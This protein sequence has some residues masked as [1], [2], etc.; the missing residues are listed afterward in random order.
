MLLMTEHEF[1]QLSAFLDGELL[2]DEAAQ[3]EA[4]LADSEEWQ[5]AREQLER[6]DLL[7]RRCMEVAPPLPELPGRVVSPR[8]GT[9]PAMRTPLLVAVV[10][11]VVL[12][13]LVP[14]LWTG[15]TEVPAVPTK[16]GAEQEVTVV[17]RPAPPVEPLGRGEA[18]EPALASQSDAPSAPPDPEPTDALALALAGT[19][20]GQSPAAVIRDVRTGD[21]KVYR[22]GDDVRDGVTLVEVS[23]K[24]V[25]LDKDGESIRLT[26]GALTVEP[27]MERSISGL[28]RVILAIDGQEENFDDLL[29]FAQE[30]ERVGVADEQGEPFATGTLVEREL[31]LQFEEGGAV[32]VLRGR[33]EWTLDSVVMRFQGPTPYGDSVDPDSLE[34]RFTRIPDDEQTVLG[35]L[36]EREREVRAIRD[37]LV[38]Y[39]RDH[40]MLFPVTLD[41]P[42]PEHLDSPEVFATAGDRRV[43]YDGQRRLAT[44]ELASAPRFDTYQAHLTLGERLKAYD[45]MLRKQYGG[46]A[47]LSPAT[48]LTVE[49]SDPGV[50]YTVNAR[51]DMHEK[52]HGTGRRVNATVPEQSE[53]NSWITQD[54]NNLQQLRI[55]IQ[56][57]QNEHEGYSPGGWVS[58]YPEYL[59]DPSVLTSPK[60][61][62]GTDSY[63][64]LYPGAQ[65][66]DLVAGQAGDPAVWTNDRQAA[67]AIASEIPIVLNRTDYPG[68]EPGRNV[69]YLDWHVAFVP[70]DSDEWRTYIEPHL[71]RSR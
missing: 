61:D 39:A 60:D 5:A 7:V 21:Q 62:P 25:L 1:E 24:E 57:F 29:T 53:I 46:D 17:A 2:P 35:T 14:V 54:Q 28:W 69:L 23:E 16:P 51:G 13:I 18:A 22:V 9:G 15:T 11:L 12:A 66:R 56:M 31:M 36:D 64:Y 52:L 6:A 27:P 40:E 4:R 38:A 10:L 44:L 43:T 49:Y 55:V 42:V 34:L 63:L 45:E 33:L 8:S 50:T 3:V 30:G 58:T 71:R 32:Y 67:E 41:M 26:L 68:P 70:R 47:W 19:V 37:A 48:I 59:T 20:L 65:L